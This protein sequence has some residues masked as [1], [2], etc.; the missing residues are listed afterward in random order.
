MKLED[1]SIIGFALL[2]L[3]FVAA[4]GWYTIG[5]N[6]WGIYVRW[7]QDVL[8]LVWTIGMIGF[9]IFLMGIASLKPPEA[10]Q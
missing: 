3:G 2:L 7:W 9:A 5:V 10:K 1:L 8:L 6:T 4:F